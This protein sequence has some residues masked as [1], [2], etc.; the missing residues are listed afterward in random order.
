MKKEKQTT[1]TKKYKQALYFTRSTLTSEHNIRSSEIFNY[2][3]LDL[4]LDLVLFTRLDIDLDS[5]K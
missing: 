4:D 5:S 1:T 2:W 3:Y